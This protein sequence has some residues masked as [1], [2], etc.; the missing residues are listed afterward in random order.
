MFEELTKQPKRQLLQQTVSLGTQAAKHNRTSPRGPS[1]LT[2]TSVPHPSCSLT[3]LPFAGLII[4]SALMIWKSLIVFTGSE[5]PIVVVLS[6][7][8]EP[9][10]YRG[11]I[12]FLHQPKGPIH[13]GDIIVFNT[14]GREIPIVHRVIKVH[15]DKKG[16]PLI[17]TKGDNNWGDDRS[18]YPRGMLWLSRSHVMGKVV[19]FLP[20]MGM[21]T[22]IFN[23]Y[24]IVKYAM[25]GLLG[26]FVL[27]SKE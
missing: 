2:A 27:T 4:T 24:P 20:H 13:S 18:L 10:F 7:S 12:L 5:S 23:D 1:P 25:I 17:L 15:E 8:M 3:V 14:D 22:I 11:D 21:V 26:L 19:G 16:D 9:G 6:G